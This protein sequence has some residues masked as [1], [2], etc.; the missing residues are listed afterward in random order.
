MSGFEVSCLSCGYGKREVIKDVSFNV[1]RGRVVGLIGANGSGKT[2]LIKAIASILPHNGKCFFDGITLEDMSI[3]RLSKICSY[4]PQRSGI[5]IDISAL[6][7]VVMGLNPHLGIFEQPSAE[8]IERS[9]AALSLVG[10]EIE[11]ETNYMKL[12]E[13]QKAL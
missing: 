10:L 3:S 12:S 7:I 13:G 11:A 2:T 1:E 5:S 9:R 4:I 6:D 8:M